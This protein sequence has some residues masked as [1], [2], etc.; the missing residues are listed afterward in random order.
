MQRPQPFRVGDRVRAQRKLEDL[1]LGVIGTIQAV[2]GLNDLYDVLFD[3]TTEPRIMQ[4]RAIE[5]VPPIQHAV[6]ADND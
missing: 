4:G 2:I 6:N 5:L 3:G 1:P